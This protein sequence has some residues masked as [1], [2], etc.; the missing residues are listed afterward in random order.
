MNTG[1]GHFN[2]RTAAPGDIPALIAL[3]QT[4][5]GDDIKDIEHFFDVYF[6]PVLTSVIDGGGMPVAAAYAVPDGDLVLPDGKRYPCAM[7]YAVAVHPE[8][9]GRGYGAAVSRDAARLAVKAGFPAA[10]LKPADDGL[11]E[12]YEK[13]TDF[14]A[15][16]NAYEFELARN[17]L[18]QTADIAFSCVS[19]FEYRRLRNHF[20]AG[21]AYIDADVRA[22]GYQQYL[23]D[24]SGG[25]L[26]AFSEDG[27]EIG[28]AVVERSGGDALIKELLLADCC[29]PEDAVS[30]LAALWDAERFFVRTPKPYGEIRGTLRRFGMILPMTVPTG[31]INAHSAT[32]YG[33]AFD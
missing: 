18:N 33:P 30:S 25:G 11:F 20:L 16:F 32:W 23:S 9:R 26:Y 6:T 17:D 10:V 3:W 7:I 29:R 31:R 21:T 19:P 2:T 1:G 4:V 12:F 14:R 5:F 22:L 15:F 13:H 28:C 8:Y 24:S 27:A